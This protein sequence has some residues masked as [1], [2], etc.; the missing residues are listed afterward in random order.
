MT[1]AALI[2]VGG[3]ILL[4]LAGT[5]ILD[6]YWPALLFASG[7]VWGAVRFVRSTPAPYALVQ[8][9]D[10]RLQTQDT[11]STAY[12][13]AGHP[14]AGLA[15]PEFRECQFAAADA[16][17]SRLSPSEAV[18]LRAPRYAWALGALVLIAGG[19]VGIRYGVLQT[20]SLSAPLAQIRFDTFRSN[21]E[22][23]A[24][25][26]KR[27]E[28]NFDEQ[29][30]KMGLVLDEEKAQAAGD[31]DKS[32][33]V[34]QSSEDGEQ[35]QP[36]GEEKKGRQ[37]KNSLSAEENASEDKAE[38]AEG[39]QQQPGDSGP[40]DQQSNSEK[41]QSQ[42]GKPQQD[43]NGLMDK[44]KN[45]LANLLAKMKA[46]PQGGNGEKQEM[47]SNQKSNEPGG[48]PGETPDPNGTPRNDQPGQQ[49]QQGDPKGD[50]QGEGSE[51][52]Q[53]GQ[54]KQS[55]DGSDKPS[56]QDSKT[57]AGKQDGAK[58]VKM[59]EQLEAMGKISE[60]L[61]RRSQTVTGEMMVE[62][63]SGKQQLK[64]AWGQRQAAHADAGG[65]IHRDE[66]PLLLQQYVQQYFEEV[67]KAPLPPLPSRSPAKGASN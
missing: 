20:L 5:Q 60:I 39:G 26:K 4:L 22:L 2:G 35:P 36:G 37:G 19:L 47:A 57:G 32:L 24:Q 10:E 8:R 66:V 55:Q 12:Y 38:R 9:I 65:E 41:K 63:S 14:D 17:A 16:L 23:A 43:S 3:V 42:S 25:T 48:K 15:C 21:E 49:G 45:A 28:Q 64:T 44:M 7:L 54:G 29:M 1:F 33:E 34:T 27:Q 59:A 53:G 6:W 11:L 58:D 46:K 40:T 13:F 67:R 61:G 50:P 52:A 31:K 18:P 56:N 51:K 30:R 62:V